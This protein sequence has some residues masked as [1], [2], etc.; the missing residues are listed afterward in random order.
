MDVVVGC[1]ARD[2]R[3]TVIASR[4]VSEQTHENV[5]HFPPE[6]ILRAWAPD[7]GIRKAWVWDR[8]RWSENI[9]RG[10]PN[11]AQ[12][13]TVNL[14]SFD[15]TCV[16]SG[17]ARENSRWNEWLE[18]EA[19]PAVGWLRRCIPAQATEATRVVPLERVV[20]NAE[21][22][23]H[24]IFSSIVRVQGHP[25]AYGSEA[26]ARW[27][28]RQ[29]ED[30]AFR[31]QLWEKLAGAW[32]ILLVVLFSGT[33][34]ISDWATIPLKTTIG[35]MLL[36]PVSPTHAVL[37]APRPAPAAQLERLLS[38]L[39]LADVSEA[40]Y[41]IQ[42]CLWPR[43]GENLADPVQKVAAAERVRSNMSRWRS[44]LPLRAAVHDEL[45]E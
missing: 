16:A 11:E 24:L 8:V 39:P 26:K 25:S 29:L 31:R 10:L 4:G 41:G 33:F 32:R 27:Y 2:A 22:V 36:L 9:S 18:S 3:R 38:G 15:T 34:A 19:A 14:R 30:A 5:S 42:I 23:A 37:A 1:R 12:R 6:F 40:V 44:I 45:G 17:D 7:A 21:A 20:G 35:E 13:G 43:P 28:L